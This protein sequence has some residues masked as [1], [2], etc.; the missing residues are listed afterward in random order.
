MQTIQSNEKDKRKPLISFVIPYY[1]LPVEMLKECIESVLLLP[2]DNYEREI[3]VIDDGSNNCIMDDISDYGND[4][5]FIRKANG[6]LSDARNTGIRMAS[7]IYIQFIDGDDCLIPSA[8][9]HCIELAKLKEPDM[10]MFEFT[11]QRHENAHVKNDFKIKRKDNDGYYDTYGPMTGTEFMLKNNIK[12]TACGYLFKKNVL[13]T[14]RFTTG[15]VHEDEEFTPQLIV[16]CE[17][18]YSLPVKAYFYR[19][20]PES[21]T[22]K[23]SADW[24]ERRTNDIHTVIQRLN[25]FA[26]TLPSV[27][28]LAMQRRVAQLTMDYIYNIIVLGMKREQINE[29][30]EQLRAEGL[31]PLP[32]RGYTQKYQWFRKMTA[33]KIGLNILIHTLPLLRKES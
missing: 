6:G 24:K 4:I 7:G 31:F 10:I 8:Y 25:T 21:I 13:M 1:N 16:R 32:D 33:N 29:R 20:R 14:L 5:I 22:S 3:I 26:D 19:T 9:G 30:I 11:R 17:Q 28:R 18:I 15:I 12:A 2:L 23:K 27:D